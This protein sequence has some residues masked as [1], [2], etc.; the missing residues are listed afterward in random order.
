MKPH[1]LNP[2]QS[3]PGVHDEAIALA[4]CLAGWHVERDAL[5]RVRLQLR[6]QVNIAHAVYIAF[7]EGATVAR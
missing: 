3:V 7:R 4:P 1:R 6:G 5:R 2:V